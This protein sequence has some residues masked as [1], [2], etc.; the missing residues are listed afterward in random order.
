VLLPPPV[1]AS[2]AASSPVAGPVTLAW[3]ASA[4]AT[5]YVVIQQYNGG[6]WST[7]YDGGGTSATF[8]TPSS[9]TYQY[10]VQACNSSGCSGYRLSNAV[11]ITLPPASAPGV[12]G[13]GTSTNGAYTITWSGVGGAT[14]YNVFENVNG[15]GWAQ[16]ANTAGGSW[17]LGDKPNGTYYYAVQAC[18]AGGCGPWSGQAVVT[19]ALP[20]VT[21]SGVSGGRTGQAYKRHYEIHWNAVATTTN[22]QIERTIPGAGIDYQDAGTTPSSIFVEDTGEVVGQIRMRVRA[23]NA[24]GCSSWSGYVYAS[25]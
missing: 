21:P 24:S 6:G 13:G 19:V 11:G 12:A 18:N 8:G 5:R 10:Q 15:G 16:I 23:C 14:S 25:F 1:P 7:V 20:P 22:Y 17:G 3:P 4:T 2:A 9:G